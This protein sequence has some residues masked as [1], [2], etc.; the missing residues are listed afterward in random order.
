VVATYSTSTLRAREEGERGGNVTRR[1]E[2][3]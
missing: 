1:W 3:T 2:E